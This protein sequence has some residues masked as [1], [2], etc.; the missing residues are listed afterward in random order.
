[1]ALFEVVLVVTALLCGLVAGLL[2]AFAVVVM[3][4]LKTMDDAAYVRA[5]QA[6]DGVIQRGQPLFGI[7]WFGSAVAALVAAGVG[8]SV[9]AGAE[10]ALAIAAAA[11]WILGVQVPTFTVHLPL[12][13]RMQKNAV[14]RREFEP[15]W[16][17]WNAFR[18][19]CA[20]LA[21]LLWLAVLLRLPG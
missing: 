3:P 16:N 1:M 2:F 21:T 10:L 14:T 5:F 13:S 17:R 18:T 20:A 15:R 6:I 8:A 4:G 9:L 19:W 12:N 7:V 11:L